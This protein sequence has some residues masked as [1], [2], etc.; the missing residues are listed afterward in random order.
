MACSVMDWSWDNARRRLVAVAKH[1]PGPQEAG[2]Q[3]QS[4]QALGGVWWWMHRSWR[5]VVCLGLGLIRV[6]VVMRWRGWWLVSRLRR[7]LGIWG[8]VVGR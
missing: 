8:A 6:C 1:P 5:G 7:W 4:P 3:G 2:S